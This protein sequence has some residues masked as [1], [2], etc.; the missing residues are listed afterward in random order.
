MNSALPDTLR[1]WLER[2]EQQHP[3]EIDLSLDRVRRVHGRLGLRPDAGTSIVVAGTNGKGSCA[4]YLESI[5]EA[6]GIRTGV[7][8]SPHLRQF[9]ERIR[10]NGASVGDL[11][12]VAAFHRVESARMDVTL[13]Y[14]EYA[15]LAALCIFRDRDVDLCIL[16]VGMGGR[17]DAVN[18]VDG[19]VSVIS[20][21]GLDHQGWLGE[22]RNAIAFEK[23]GV[24]RRDQPAVIGERDP[25]ESIAQVAAQTGARLLQIGLDFDCERGAR[26]WSWHGCVN[27]FEGLP[28]PQ[29]GGREQLIN[30]SCALAAV[31]QLAVRFRSDASHVARGLSAAR[32]PGRFQRIEREQSWILDVAH[33]GEAAVVL[34]DA[35]SGFS[36]RTVAVIGM[37]Q[38]KP[39][40]AV[41]TALDTQIDEWIAVSDGHPRSLPVAELA[42]RLQGCVGSP[43]R[44]AASV[45]AGLAAAAERA[46]KTDRILVAGSFHV[47]GPALD[48]L[49]QH[50]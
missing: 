16:E 43:V 13:T 26:N 24:F 2:I 42:Q 32:L 37:M 4:A 21:I 38:A 35:L 48:Y 36:G 41:A 6:T 33:N 30:A 23:A 22:D 31:E 9:H 18:V 39:V 34:A 1:A 19:A 40:E 5:F 14:F 46:G 10:V 25:P 3:T 8:T 27:N 50:G 49:S 47:V 15:T 12:I 11:D 44:S 45:D 17:L 20:S 28:L 7:Y 29:F